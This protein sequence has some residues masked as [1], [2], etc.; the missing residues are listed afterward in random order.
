MTTPADPRIG[1]AFGAARDYDGRAR[2]Q[3]LVAERLAARIAALPRP[4]P[5]HGLELGCGTGFLTA[6][7]QTEAIGGTWLVTDLAPGMVARCR[8]R[9]GAQAGRTPPDL[10]FAVLDGEHGAMPAQGPFDLICASL[11]FQWFAD[12]PAA[13]ARLLGWLTPGGHLVF[14]TLGAG[15]FAEWREAH[16]AEGLAAGTPPFPTVAALAAILPEWQAAAPL[17][18][19]EIERHADARAFLHSLKAIGAG[20]PGLHHRP[21]PPGALRRVMARFEQAGARSTYEV[22]TCHYRRET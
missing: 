3:R 5:P 1:A 15:T 18:E 16:A 4:H 19:P 14:T 12:L 17:V 20:T 11:A 6:A 7:L 9:L 8:A 2:V 13:I 22:V 10:A 21:L